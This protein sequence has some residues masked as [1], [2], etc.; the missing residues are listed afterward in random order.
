MLI[1]H[2]LLEK[3]QLYYSDSSELTDQLIVDNVKYYID[4][5]S[6][7]SNGFVGF[8]DWLRHDEFN[9]IGIR[10]CFFE[11]HGYNKLFLTFPYV[12]SSFEGK[13]VEIAFGEEKYN[14]DISGDQD[15]S[16]N[17]VYRSA[18]NDYL[19]TF[20]LDHLTESE[21]KSLKKYCSLI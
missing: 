6:K 2:F 13:C 8:F 14:A 18:T 9:I 17:Y 11:H 4:S 7:E 16:Q 12:K 10:I 3:C 5:D 20:N 15:F 1:I 19:V 21:L